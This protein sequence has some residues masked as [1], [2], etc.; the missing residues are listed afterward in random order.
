MVLPYE[1]QLGRL[2]ATLLALL[3]TFLLLM[4]T[5]PVT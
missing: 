3:I 1:Y 4:S 5:R 2:V